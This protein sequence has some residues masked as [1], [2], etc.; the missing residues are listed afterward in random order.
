MRPDEMILDL[1]PFTAGVAT[2]RRSVIGGFDMQYRH[3]VIMLASL[4]VSI[5]PMIALFAMVGMF[6]VLVPVAVWGAMFSLF[7]IRSRTGMRQYRYQELMRR[8]S[9]E[10]HV[11]LIGEEVFDLDSEASPITIYRGAT[12]PS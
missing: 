7:A 5:I 1:T 10:Q 4:A 9:K 6:A 8:G 11:V 12:Q 3:A 2:S